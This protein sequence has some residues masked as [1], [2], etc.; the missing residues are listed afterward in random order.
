MVCG[1]MSPLWRSVGL[2][3]TRLS[4]EVSEVACSA[5]FAQP[6]EAAAAISAMLRIQNLRMRIVGCPFGLRRRPSRTVESST[7]HLLVRGSSS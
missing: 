6:M 3:A 4:L 7:P 2:L 1:V 5:F